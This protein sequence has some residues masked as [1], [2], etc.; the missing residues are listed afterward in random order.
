M[1]LRA[2]CLSLAVKDLVAREFY[3]KPGFRPT[4]GD[5][6]RNRLVLRNG[7]GTTCEAPLRFVR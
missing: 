4:A 3:E 5:P 7:Q 6:A 1:K 2:F